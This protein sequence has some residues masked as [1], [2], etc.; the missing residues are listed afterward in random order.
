MTLAERG[1]RM[2]APRR[3]ARAIG[4][5]CRPRMRSGVK[6]RHVGGDRDLGL[7]HPRLPPA[8]CTAAARR[9][10]SGARCCAPWCSGRRPRTRAELRLKR[11]FDEHRLST[12]RR[13]GARDPARG[14]A[15]TVPAPAR[16]GILV[17]RMARRADASGRRGRAGGGRPRRRAGRRPTTLRLPPWPTSWARSAAGLDGR[18]RA[19]A[20][21]GGVRT[22]SLALSLALLVSSVAEGGCDPVLVRRAGD[23][24][25]RLCSYRSQAIA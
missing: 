16:G 2:R 23:D 12:L 24:P 10:P 19:G 21:A 14:G 4:A 15:S 5:A 22:F 13:S 8:A 11:W 3:G 9:C 17:H 18:R 20:G 6:R 7:A 1:L 25:A